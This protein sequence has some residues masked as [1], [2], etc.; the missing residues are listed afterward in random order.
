MAP[1]WTIGQTNAELELSVKGPAGLVAV[2]REMHS[3]LVVVPWVVRHPVAGGE[4]KQPKG[5]VAGVE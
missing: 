4:A 2:A 5:I 3:A 1:P